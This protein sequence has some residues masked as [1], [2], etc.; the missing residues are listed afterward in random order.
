MKEKKVVAI[1][2][3]KCLRDKTGIGKYIA[4]FVQYLS[5]AG[6]EFEFLLLGDR[7]VTE[8]E[9]PDGCQ[10]LQ[11]GRF[12]RED[13]KLA[14]LYSPFWLNIA[15]TRV[16]RL[17]KVALF[18]GPNFVIPIKASCPCVTTI[19]DLAFLKVP[20]AY[21]RI[22]RN[23]IR[24]QVQS[25]VKRAVAIIVVSEAAKRDLISLMNVPADKIYVI[26]HGIDDKFQPIKE[27]RFL[28]SISKQFQLPL[29][30]LLSVGVIE[31]RKNITTLLQA[32]KP[33][34]KQGLTDGVVLA[35]KDGL[36]ADEV[37]Q[38]AADLEICDQVYFLGYV[39]DE[40][41]VGLYNLAQCLV[42]PSWYE[43][44]GMPI[45]EAMACGCPVVA[46]DSSSI[47]EAAGAAA[48]LFPPGDANALESKLR[49]LLTSE[50]LRNELVS[51]GHKWARH[52]TWQKSAA[53]HLEVYRNVLAKFY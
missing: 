32:A 3:R 2:I 23:Y 46:S 5:Q 47:P 18:H 9:I 51:E 22:Y 15:V 41:L 4:G 31:R 25:A 43:G 1:D 35:G 30:F 27:Q 21:T 24:F 26:Y 11:I 48:L 50:L 14:Q 42:F 44:F 38:F 49:Q 13:G 40:Q 52:F 37:R 12:Y 16:L 29:R 39:S 17:K 28:E 19:H 45:L 8:K 36:G 7:S 10:Y 34:I 6:S 53:E 20:D 33:L